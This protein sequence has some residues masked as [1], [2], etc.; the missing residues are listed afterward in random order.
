MASS[1][2]FLQAATIQDL[3]P[4][5]PENCNYSWHQAKISSKLQLFLASSQDFLQVASVHDLKRKFPSS[6]K[7]SWP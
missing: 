1:Q 5:F 6:C 2:D 4:R 7:S 3:K